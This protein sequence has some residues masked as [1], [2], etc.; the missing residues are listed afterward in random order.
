ML[1]N[2]IFISCLLPLFIYLYLSTSIEKLIYFTIFSVFFP[3]QIRLFGSDALTSGSIFIFILCLRYFIEVYTK[4]SIFVDICDYYV[5]ILII[6]SVLSVFIPF[7]EGELNGEG[8]GQALRRCVAYVSSLLLFVIVKNYEI[9]RDERCSSSIDY[10]ERIISITLLLT[11][12]HV[13]ISIVVVLFPAVAPIFK[14][15]LS[16]N[17]DTLEMVKDAKTE[18]VRIR[19]FVFSPEKYGE[20]LAATGPFIVYKIINTKSK[21]WYFCL[22]IFISGLISA[23]TR[24]G[25]ILFVLGIV[26]SLL[27]LKKSSFS[28]RTVF[29]I[30]TI[31]ITIILITLQPKLI[32]DVFF[33]F[34]LAVESYNEGARFY[35]ILNRGLWLEVYE[36]VISHLTILGNGI[37]HFNYHNLYLS[38]L[39]QR[40]ILGLLFFVILILCVLKRLKYAYYSKDHPN[41]RNI[42]FTCFLFMVLFFINEMKFEFIR[43]SSYQQ[44]CWVALGVCFLV[45]QSSYTTQ[46][47]RVLND[48]N[49][50][51]K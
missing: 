13:C 1:I 3:I 34:N 31:S 51:Y 24:S 43:H 45:G 8:L 26:L 20:F 33:R 19:S 46:K 6:L 22:A 9:V 12:I 15:F 47:A 44:I 38:I 40:G 32:Q 27:F 49:A 10:T 37:S 14:I 48:D 23:N 35:E 2:I 36:V 42:V 41:N 39:H 30:F 16:K 50:K 18:I 4:R 21:I 11:S 29:F 5:Y 28:Q 25:I 17:V 7:L